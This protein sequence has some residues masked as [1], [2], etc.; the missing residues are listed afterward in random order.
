MEARAGWG[1]LSSGTPSDL[2]VGR[3]PETGVWGDH[4]VACLLRW[5][6]QVTVVDRTGEEAVKGGEMYVSAIHDV[7]HGFLYVQ[8]I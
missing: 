8:G 4:R 5:F 7:E 3:I 6:R 1:A 2:G